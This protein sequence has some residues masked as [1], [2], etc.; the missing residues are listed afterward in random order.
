[1]AP[2]DP[3]L[4]NERKP[5]KQHS[6]ADFMETLEMYKSLL[7]ENPLVVD[8]NC[9]YMQ[10][11]DMVTF[12]A[13]IFTAIVTPAEV[14]FTETTWKSGLFMVNRVVDIIFIKDMCLQFFVAYVDST[15]GARLVKDL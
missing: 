14:A 12:S 11:W 9:K 3:L 5:R 7:R 10:K 15:Q 8:P 1:M 4:S 2:V 6:K 13:L